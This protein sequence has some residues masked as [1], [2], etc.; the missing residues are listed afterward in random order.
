MEAPVRAPGPRTVSDRLI[1]LLGDLA[2]VATPEDATAAPD[3]LARLADCCGAAACQLDTAVTGADEVQVPAFQTVATVG[4][5][6]DVSSHLCTELARS[7]HGRLV[8]DAPTGRRIAD[9]TFDFRASASY[10]DVLHPAGYADGVSIA[11]RDTHAQLVGLLHLSAHDSRDFAPELTGALRPLGQAFARLTT[12]ATCSTPDVTLPREYA[13]AR[14]DAAGRPTPVVGRAPLHVALDE[15]LMGIVRGV[16]G[17]RTE[18]ATFLH[19]QNGRLVEVRVHAPRPGRGRQPFTIATR[20]APTTL[21]LT[22]RQ[23]EVLTAVATGAGNRDI[24]E[25]LCLTQRTVAA[26]V[27]AILSRLGVSS[28]AGAAAKATAAGVLL[29]NADPDSVRSLARVLQRP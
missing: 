23:L 3:L 17:T 24:A 20:P 14:V 7:P 8:L 4:Y 10:R 13:V 5:D 27:E 9:D 6:P 22:L 11:L 2:S 21:G 16:L 1:D 15:E 26:H 29:P 18:F 25:E 12:V 19:Q 28:R